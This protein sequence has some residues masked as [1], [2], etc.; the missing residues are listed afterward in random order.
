MALVLNP[1]TGQYEEDGTGPAPALGQTAAVEIPGAGQVIPP[2][3]TDVLRPGTLRQ[4]FGS[5]RA[6]PAVLAGAVVKPEDI[7]PPPPP[8]PTPSANSGQPAQQMPTADA[9][10]AADPL[11]ALRDVTAGQQDRAAASLAAARAVGPDITKSSQWQETKERTERSEGEKAAQAKVIGTIEDGKA[12]V[13]KATAG[14]AAKADVAAEFAQREAELAQAQQAQREAQDAEWQKKEDLA[15]ARVAEERQRYAS[16]KITDLFEGREASGMIAALAV[17]LGQYASARGGGPNTSLAIIDSAR[18]RLFQR[19]QA[20]INKQLQVYE[21]TRA[22]ASDVQRA[23]AEARAKLHA[24]QAGILTVLSKE[25][26]ARLARFG[27]D[28]ARI[29][30]DALKNALDEKAAR[31]AL[32]AEKAGRQVIRMARGGSSSV[33]NARQNDA[34]AAAVMAAR[35]GPDKPA[36]KWSDGEKRADSYLAKAK[37]EA[38]RLSGI[39]GYSPKD[40]R[41]IESWR[42]RM[43]SEI[44]DTTVEKALASARALSGDLLKRLSPEGRQRFNAEMG[45]VETTL[46]P[47]TGAAISGGEY[48]DRLA[49]IQASKG[50]TPEIVQQKGERVLSYLAGM[51]TQTGRPGYWSREL[52]SLQQ[53]GAPAPMPAAQVAEAMRWLE[54]NPGDPR[55]PQVRAALQARRR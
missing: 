51:A 49:G 24:Q 52:T 9:P 43:S 46:R 3:P 48:V 14:K 26:E 28:D 7:A 15:A 20:E 31:E 25:R 39:K 13:D 32:E 42:A 47:D 2:D 23:K 12:L 21:M 27:A 18:A 11:K 44:G 4:A 22:D 19:Q 33:S 29:E 30:G 6:D 16:M 45:F 41:E 17:G 10:P 37:A 53:G 34:M 55:A 50:D 40:Q 35:S 54:E 38:E 1:A 5:G 36:D 8:A